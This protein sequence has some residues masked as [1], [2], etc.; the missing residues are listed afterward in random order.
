MIWLYG[1]VCVC[2]YI[3]IYMSHII[4]SRAHV[5]LSCPG[6]LMLELRRRQQMLVRDYYLLACACHRPD[7]AIRCP[8]MLLLFTPARAYSHNEWEPR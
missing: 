1:Y 2:I 3:Y 8:Y 5:H 7:R 6:T 4:A